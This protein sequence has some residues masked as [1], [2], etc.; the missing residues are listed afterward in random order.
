M[1]NRISRWSREIRQGKRSFSD[2]LMNKA[3][4]LVRKVTKTT[5]WATKSYEVWLLL[6]NL[7]FLV[8]PKKILEF[9]SGRSTNYLAEY[10][11]KM[12]AEFISIEHNWY[13]YMK[14]KSGLKFLFLDTEHLK[15]VPIDGSWYDIK[16]LKRFLAGY[17][18]I[19]FLFVDGPNN[20]PTDIRDPEVFYDFMTDKLKNIRMVLIDDTHTELGKQLAK[21]MTSKFGLSRFDVEYSAGPYTNR[22]AI[23]LDK[24]SSEKI[25]DLPSYSSEMLLKI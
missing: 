3:G 12:N 7:L 17:D 25:N 2:G 23:L 18:G 11:G 16:K 22:L 10:A 5:L 20:S 1:G 21:K 6:L 19:D 8:R 9:G 13:Y 15:Y 4:H 14:V 24:D